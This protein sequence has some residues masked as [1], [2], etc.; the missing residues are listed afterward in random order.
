MEQQPTVSRGENT[1]GPSLSKQVGAVAQIS[2]S[3]AG[4]LERRK[5]R[6]SRGPRARHTQTVVLRCEQ[7][8]KKRR[9]RTFCYVGIS[10]RPPRSSTTNAQQDRQLSKADTVCSLRG[11]GTSVMLLGVFGKSVSKVWAGVGRAHARACGRRCVPLATSLGE[12][13]RRWENPKTLPLEVLRIPR[14]VDLRGIPLRSINLLGVRFR[15]T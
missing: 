2:R 1:A 10:R 12:L 7:P 5:R 8:D 13:S 15:K 11:P 9:A 4:N 6:R 3:H 14:M